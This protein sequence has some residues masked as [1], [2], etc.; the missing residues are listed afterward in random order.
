MSRAIVLIHGLGLGEWVFE[1]HFTVQFQAAGY[2][3]HTFNLPGHDPRVSLGERQR[4]TLDACVRFVEDYLSQHLTV[5]FALLGL[6][7]GGG[8]IQR[9]LAGGY[10]N[11][12]LRAVVLL[13]SMPPTNNLL[14]TLRLCNR[15]ALQHSKVLVDFFAQRANAQLV[16]SPASLGSLGMQ[17]VDAY[18]QRVLPGFTQLELEVFFANLLNERSTTD[19]PMHVI[20]GADDMLFDVDTACFTA[21]YYAQRAEIIPGLGHMIPVETNQRFAFDSIHSFLAGIF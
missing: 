16:F 19:L 14:F 4:I 20:G 1:Q 13:C 17:Q 18:L 15:L 11:T 10:R 6:S 9:L 2:E 8:I 5:P 21:G 3:V 7:M 12:L